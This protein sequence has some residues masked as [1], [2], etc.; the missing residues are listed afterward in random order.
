MQNK[1]PSSQRNGRDDSSTTASSPGAL[2]R[3]EVVREQKQAVHGYIIL[4]FARSTSI[5]IV[6]LAALTLVLIVV[7]ARVDYS[8]RVK[9]AG[10]VVPGGNFVRIPAPEDGFVVDIKI[11][12]G[13]TVRAG[14]EL[15]SLQS[16]AATRAGDT[17]AQIQSE[18]AKARLESLQQQLDGAVNARRARASDL[19]SLTAQNEARL[20]ELA[21]QITLQLAELE[22]SRNR[23]KR[24]KSLLSKQFVSAVEVD[25]QVESELRLEQ[26]MRELYRLQSEART[27][28]LNNMEASTARARADETEIARLSGEKSAVEIELEQFAYAGG[29]TVTAPVSGRISQVGI[30]QGRALQKGGFA[31]SIVDPDAPLEIEAYAPSSAAGQLE[32][33]ATVVLRFDSFPYQ[34][35]GS[36]RGKILSIS[37]AATQAGDL[38]NLGFNPT[39]KDLKETMFYKV[40]VLFDGDEIGSGSRRSKIRAGMNVEV[41]AIVERKKI[42]E[43]L[44]DPLSDFVRPIE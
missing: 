21:S 33:G 27:E 28:A 10:V 3:S 34:R 17:L 32:T 2:F 25:Q 35:F 37:E 11:V 16:Q 1:T 14:A 30:S 39:P 7:F 26:R 8:E 24:L 44:T 23:T 41:S 36:K 13:Q 22:S 43:L 40:R 31:V 29:Q 12:E 15:F 42:Y 6:F 20:R 38:T 5:G 4:R 19:E 9:L 18:L